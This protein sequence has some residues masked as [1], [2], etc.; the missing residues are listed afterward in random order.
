[1]DPALVP[2]SLER[3]L[4]QDGTEGLLALLDSAR[5]TWTD[6]MVTIAADRFERRLTQELAAFRVD[7]AREL[8]ALRTELGR[9]I[10]AVRVEM[11]SVRVEQL[12][13]AF[14]FWIG[15]VAVTAGVL[16]MLFRVFR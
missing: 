12:K 2:A 11:A 14:V 15:Q 16:T 8:A 7:V 3:R 10:V 4:G 9:E 5:S 13:W 1:M 6:D